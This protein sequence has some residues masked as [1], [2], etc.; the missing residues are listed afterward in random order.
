VKATGLVLAGAASA[1]LA[2]YWLTT[3][4]VM[5]LEPTLTKL[6]WRH[7]NGRPTKEKQC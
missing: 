2:G 3:G 7:H 6:Y 1:A 4:I 5:A